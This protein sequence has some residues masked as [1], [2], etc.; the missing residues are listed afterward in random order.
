M[1]LSTTTLAAAADAYVRDG[2]TY[3]NSNFGTSAELQLKDA[4][5][6][7]NRESF[8]K[9]DTS[10][11]AASDAVSSAKLRVYG[12]YDA[13]G[14]GSVAV[15]PVASTT[16]GET[17][18]TWATKPAAGSALDTKTVTGDGSAANAWYEFDV[19]SYVSSER[20]ASRNTVALSMDPTA[21]TPSHFV[22]VSDEASDTHDPELLVQHAPAAA[23]T[24][25]RASHDAHVRDGTYA[26]SNF[27][28][29]TGLEAKGGSA[30]DF[31]R[32]TYLKFTVDSLDAVGT[33]TVRLYGSL[34]GT[35]AS[36]PLAAFG[37]T[38]TTWTEAGITWNTKPATTGSALDTTTIS[39][40]AGQWYEW[41]VTSY[42]KAEVA[43]G[44][45][46]VT[47]A[48]VPATSS[49]TNPTATF[50]SDEAAGNR[51]ELAVT[52]AASTAPTNVVTGAQMGQVTVTWDAVAG[53]GCYDV[54]RSTTEGDLGTVVGNHV[55]G[56]SFV[57]TTVV[58]G[59]TY[60][61]TVKVCGSVG[62][63]GQSEQSPPTTPPSVPG[64]IVFGTV[65]ATPFYHLWEPQDMS[66]QRRF[67][68][69]NTMPYF[70]NQGGTLELSSAKWEYKS[71]ATRITVE[72]PNGGGVYFTHEAKSQPAVAGSTST[73]GVVGD[74]TSGIPDA[75]EITT[76]DKSGFANLADVD[77]L[78]FYR[79]VFE[80]MAHPGHNPGPSQLRAY[81]FFKGHHFMHYQFRTVP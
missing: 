24:V 42:V 32:H 34:S 10:A 62:G 23:P 20:A 38:N 11:I 80:L 28:T 14:S 69:H 70:N 13:S 6:G 43:A 15:R 37:V 51:P 21:A 71:V 16:W 35:A 44:R 4:S 50:N 2:T 45:N 12:R 3:Q 9:F 68:G 75:I 73:T 58:N 36:P 77:K 57:D 29:A 49:G 64:T 8:L 76:P 19:T 53:A 41:D 30:L 1:F 55:T 81:G 47:I 52:A 54:Y 65:W 60:Y 31:T 27:G 74:T 7:Y 22:F 48:I 40:T 18:I 33:A 79:I 59:T 39:G 66:V 26:G 5:V 61:Y 46:T 78:G 56:T 17:T 25:Y 67:P 63:S 72:A